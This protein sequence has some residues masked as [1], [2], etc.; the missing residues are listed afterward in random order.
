M[1]HDVS[2]SFYFLYFFY[3][4]FNGGIF[5]FE[6]FNTFLHSQ[7]LLFFNN[8]LRETTLQRFNNRIAI[9]DYVFKIHIGSRKFSF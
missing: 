2:Y 4:Y 1:E 5:L 3:I 9:L 8:V 6:S 7:L